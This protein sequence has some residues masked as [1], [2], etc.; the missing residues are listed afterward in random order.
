MEAVDVFFRRDGQQNF[1]GVNLRG[2]GQLHQNAVDLIAAVQIV[3]QRQQ[4][5]GS[6]IVSGRVLLAVDA[7]LLAGFHLVANV[8]FG[9]WIVTGKHHGQ[10]GTKPGSGEFFYLFC[11]LCLDLRCDFSSVENDGRHGAPSCCWNETPVYRER[12]S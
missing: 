11:D 5:A 10:S 1:L 4:L 7:K 3:D 8:D 2:Q 9:S 12:G 6:D